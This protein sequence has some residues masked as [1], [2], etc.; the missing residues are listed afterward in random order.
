MIW[1]VAKVKE[2]LTT[3]DKMVERSLC[4]LYARQTIEE[5]RTHATGASNSMGFNMNDAEFLSSLAEQV[6]QSRYPVGQRLSNKQRV[7]ARRRLMKYAKQLTTY[8]NS[9]KEVQMQ[10]ALGLNDYPDK[11][12]RAGG[13]FND[14]LPR[15]R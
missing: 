11:L 3:N 15:K 5:R 4:V 6:K 10:S 8:A 7:I 14:N 9:C 2:L 1:T 13:T 12:F